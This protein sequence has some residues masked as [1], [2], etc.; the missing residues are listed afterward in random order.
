MTWEELQ[1]LKAAQEIL[2]RLAK[3]TE[4]EIYQAAADYVET[5]VDRWEAKP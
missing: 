4:Q 3:E 5:C 2:E 1:T